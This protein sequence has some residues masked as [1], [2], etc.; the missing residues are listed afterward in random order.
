MF[1]G[2]KLALTLAFVVLVSLA[3]GASCNGFFVDPTIS[4]I[5]VGPTGQN[6]EIGKTL[7]MGARASYDDG[8]SKNITG[9]ATWLS[10]DTNVATITSA[11]LV[12]GVALGTANITASKDAVTSNSVA[13]NI[14]LTPSSITI[15]PDHLNVKANGGSVTCQAFAQPQGVDISAQVTWSITSSANYTLTQGA[16]PE[17]ITTNASAQVNETDTLTA[18]YKVGSTQ[19]T[20]TA[21]VTVTQ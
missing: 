7:Q 9:S 19:F 13:V 10:D 12:T 2:R 17:T 6:L 21:Q 15:T 8:S 5:T 16:S 3:F 1:S 20:A 4:S 18:T 14:V 11:G